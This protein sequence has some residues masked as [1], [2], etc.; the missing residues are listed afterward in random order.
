MTHSIQRRR[1]LVG[2]AAAIASASVG[3]AWLRGA[4]GS[5]AWIEHVVRSNLPG[6]EFDETALSEFVSSMARHDWFAPSSHRVAIAVDRTL[7]WVAARVP[8]VREGLEKLERRVLTE[9]LIG[10]NFFRVPDPRA[11]TI[12][13]YGPAIACGNPFVSLS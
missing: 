10:S 5:E 8:K 9:F 11:E 1:F 3:F 7:P 2:G 4:F 12:V 13:Y 6:I